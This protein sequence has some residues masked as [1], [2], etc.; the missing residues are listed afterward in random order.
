MIR[1]GIKGIVD[2]QESLETL[3][4]M[5]QKDIL[6]QVQIYFFVLLE[7]QFV[8]LFQ[9]EKILG[10]EIEGIEQYLILRLS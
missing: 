8:R 1:D 9:I 5:L 10:I 7:S 3:R 6:G 2:T 4:W